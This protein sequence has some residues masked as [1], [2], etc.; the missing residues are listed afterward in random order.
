VTAYPDHHTR[1][2]KL[3]FPNA[4]GSPRGLH[5]RDVEMEQIL[6]NIGGAH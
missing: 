1:L 3:H 4:W 5:I 2:D 6:L